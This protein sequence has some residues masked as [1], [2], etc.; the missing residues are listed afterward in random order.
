MLCRRYSGKEMLDWG[1]VNAVVPMDNLDEE[2]EKWANEIMALSPTVIGTVK[3]SFRYMLDET[4]KRDIHQ[5]LREVRPNFYDTG[6]QL[7]GSSA[8]LE[9]RKPDFSK[10]R[11]GK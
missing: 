9:K 3:E 10:Y 11:F 5:V 8:F 7:E 6:E 1:L 4:M 2:V